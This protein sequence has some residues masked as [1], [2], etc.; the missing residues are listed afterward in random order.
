M[1]NIGEQ[2]WLPIISLAVGLLSCF[3]GY[4]LRRLTIGIF[5]FCL[6]LFIGSGVT[7][8]MTEHTWLPW[9]IGVIVGILFAL[10]GFKVYRLGVFLLCGGVTFFVCYLLIQTQWLGITVGAIAGIIMGCISLKFLKPAIIFSTAICSGLSSGSL[11]AELFGLTGIWITVIG[12]VL[13]ALGCLFQFY[14]SREK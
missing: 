6:G 7:A 3:F 5:S 12:V 10:I 14:N 13:A 1:S 11:A 2:Q 9:L 4:R 8:L